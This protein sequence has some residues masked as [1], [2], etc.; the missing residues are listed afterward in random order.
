MEVQIYLFSN[1]FPGKP[2]VVACK[3]LPLNL[4]G[5]RRREQFFGGSN[6]LCSAV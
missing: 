2:A 6:G 1:S 3:P 4:Q 5:C